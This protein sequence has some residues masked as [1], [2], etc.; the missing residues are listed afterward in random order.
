MASSLLALIDDI[1]TVLDDI[2]LLTKVAAKKTAGVLGDRYV[3]LQL[4]GET[5]T[6][7]NGGVIDF[8]ESAVLLERVLGKI[9]RKEVPEPASDS[10]THALELSTLED[11]I[12]EELL[13]QKA[14]ELKITVADADIT[15]TVD[16]QVSQVR[17]GF[18]TESEYRNAL[19]QSGLGTP[20]EYVDRLAKAKSLTLVT[21][22]VASLQAKITWSGRKVLLAGYL[23]ETPQS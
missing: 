15:P 21:H 1:A 9:Q 23:P 12:E 6:L 16:R 22:L 7:K 4:G 19:A 20:Q 14:N 10:A 17:A 13:L 18:A 3:S 2:S 8:T 5:E 11:M